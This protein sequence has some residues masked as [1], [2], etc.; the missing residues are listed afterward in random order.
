MTEYRLLLRDLRTSHQLSQEALAKELGISRQ[1]I[2]SLEQGEYFPSFPLLISLI[3]FF[4]CDISNIVDLPNVAHSE[5]IQTERASSNNTNE[6]IN[7]Y[8]LEDKYIFEMPAV[9]IIEDDIEIKAQD[10]SITITANP[11]KTEEGTLVHSEWVSD[12]MSRTIELPKTIDP[13]S[14][15]A[16]LKNG[17]LTILVN[18]KTNPSKVNRV[19]INAS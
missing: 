6:L 1:S 7:I 12:Q 17:L 8:E 2:I 14:A 19:K 18:K 10:D 4:E 9:G 3:D 16:H 13:D 11:Q 15:V 5:A